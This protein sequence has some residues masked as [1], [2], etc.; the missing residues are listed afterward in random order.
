VVLLNVRLVAAGPT[1]D[2]FTPENLRKTYGGRLAILDAAGEA[3]EAETRA[4]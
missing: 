3:V 1:E 2:V 4:L